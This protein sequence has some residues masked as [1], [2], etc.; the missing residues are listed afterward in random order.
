VRIVL[1]QAHKSWRFATNN[2][3]IPNSLL[4]IGASLEQ[5]GHEVVVVDPL[6]RDLSLHEL[7]AKI[8]EARPDLVGLYMT[9]D[10]RFNAFRLINEVKRVLGVPVMAGGPHPT[11]CADDTLRHVDRGRDR[12][13]PREGPAGPERHRERFVQAGEGH[14]A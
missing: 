10:S 4:Y 3:V 14:R 11:F 9:T 1:T 5:A 13:R 7:M 12:R 8:R 6:V 2:L